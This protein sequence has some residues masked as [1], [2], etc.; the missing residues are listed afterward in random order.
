MTPAAMKVIPAPKFVGKGLTTFDVIKAGWPGATD[1][2]ADY[3]LWN[4]T[5]YPMGGDVKGLFKA[6]HGYYRAT[7]NK[8]HLCALCPSIAPLG[9]YECAKCEALLA[10]PVKR[11]KAMMPTW[12]KTSGPNFYAGTPV[13]GVQTSTSTSI[14]N[15]H[16]N[17]A[18][19]TTPTASGLCG[20]GTNI[21]TAQPSAP[22]Q[23]AMYQQAALTAQNTWGT[24]YDTPN[25]QSGPDQRMISDRFVGEILLPDGSKVVI[26]KG[27]FH[28][29]DK[30]AQITYKAN[31]VREFNRF[32]NASD[33]LQAF[34][35]DLGE[36]GARQSD[37]LAVP[38][39]LF[40]N[41]LILKAAEQDHEPARGGILPRCRW[42][43]R[44]I[45][46]ARVQAGIMFCGEPHMANFM[47][48]EALA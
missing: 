31:R 33:L 7:K 30:A 17:T 16:W 47:K 12:V 28:V 15:V 41:W 44:F 46:R 11:S 27:N 19:T 4:R 21:Y 43:Q 6:A 29:E 18:N 38:I 22:N 24:A 9:K 23:V 48:R 36:A 32:L 5:P 42:C 45:S 35:A 39:E 14:S 26:D 1:Q 13:M 20:M 8:R 25:V 2:D 37:V 34:I 3:L 10:T 40:I